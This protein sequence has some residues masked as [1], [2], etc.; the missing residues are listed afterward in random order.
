MNIELHSVF[1]TERKKRKTIHIFYSYSFSNKDEL[2]YNFWNKLENRNNHFIYFGIYNPQSYNLICSIEVEVKPYIYLLFE[3]V[4]NAFYV[5]QIASIILWS[6]DSY[7]YYASCIA[8]LS[9]G[10]VIMSLLE[11]RRQSQSLHDMVSS[12]NAMKVK[13][14]YSEKAKIFC[15]IFTLLLTGTTWDKLKA[16]I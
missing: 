4:L 15:E 10:S 6:L 11:T 13:F 8:F 12:S 16:K 1:K 3:E 7:V 2:I 5:F 9:L 14:I